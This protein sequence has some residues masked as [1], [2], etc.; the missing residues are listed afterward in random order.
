MNTD[1]RRSVLICGCILCS[2]CGRNPCQFAKDFWRTTT[3]FT[4]TI[5]AIFLCSGRNRD[6]CRQILASEVVSQPELDLALSPE[7]ADRSQRAGAHAKIA[8]RCYARPRKVELR[9]VKD[10]KELGAELKLMPLNLELLEQREVEI[11]NGGP[12]KRTSC[13]VSNS[14]D[15]WGRKCSDIKLPPWNVNGARQ[16]QH[17]GNKIGPRVELA[18]PQGIAPAHDVNWQ[19]AA[20]F[21]KA[22]NLPPVLQPVRPR[23]LRGARV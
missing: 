3:N 19:A 21:R 20:H 12:A 23:W 18:Y 1:E 13:H 6:E 8:R 10:V 16:G 11:V 5:T 4:K 17:S 9:R 15:G 2:L 22:V 7:V 14:P